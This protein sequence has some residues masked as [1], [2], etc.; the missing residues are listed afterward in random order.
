M[1]HKP[2]RR[3]RDRLHP[4][5]LWAAVN[6]PKHDLRTYSSSCC[7]ELPSFLSSTLH[8]RFCS[9]VS[10]SVLRPAMRIFSH[11]SKDAVSPH[12]RRNS[13][14]T[15]SCS[16]KHTFP[17][18]LYVFVT[19]VPICCCHLCLATALILI[20]DRDSI[21]DSAS[22][23]SCG[24]WKAGRFEYLVDILHVPNKPRW[25]SRSRTSFMIRERRGSI[26]RLGLRVR[27]YPFSRSGGK[28]FV[29]MNK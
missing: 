5:S 3:M 26:P 2:S 11:T 29:C 27:I 25:V 9:V 15:A 8:T 6:L 16:G 17:P 4:R 20:I 19:H 1:G 28:V 23:A 21:Q 22:V 24:T 13:A 7:V 14:L 18:R 12:T 10:I